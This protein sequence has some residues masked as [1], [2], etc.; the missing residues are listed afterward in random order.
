[1]RHGPPAY[2]GAHNLSFK[3]DA[4]T[5]AVATTGE[6]TGI[7]GVTHSV[8]WIHCGYSAAPAAGAYIQIKDGANVVWKVPITA[9]GPAPPF[10][11]EDTGFFVTK[12]N[13]LTVEL[14]SGAGAVVGYLNVGVM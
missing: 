8:L 5:A 12:G 7:P 9:A 4:Q 11:W 6:I 2:K 1:M 3:H 13:H 10:V 14:A